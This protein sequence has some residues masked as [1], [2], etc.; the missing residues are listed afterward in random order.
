MKADIS[1]IQRGAAGV[2]AVPFGSRGN[3]RI[4]VEES[5]DPGENS[6]D[7]ILVRL[8]SATQRIAGL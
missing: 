7:A 6:Q 3:D 5:A 8:S 1:M 4:V 2:E